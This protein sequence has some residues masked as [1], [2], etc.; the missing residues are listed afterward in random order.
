MATLTVNVLTEDDDNISLVAADVAGDEY[1]NS[2]RTFL[3]VD[4]QDASSTNVTITVQTT[5]VEVSGFG[6]LTKADKV[7]AVPAGEQRWIGPVPAAYDDAS[8]NVQVS[9]SSVTSLSVAAVKA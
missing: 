1:A 6:T 4:N 7:V 5:T 9:Y 8:K 2:N 3:Y